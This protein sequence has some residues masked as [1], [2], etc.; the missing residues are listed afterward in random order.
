MIDFAKELNE[1]QFEVVTNGEG[2]CLVLAGA[3]S[4]KTRAITYRVAYLLEKGVNPNNILLVTF[5]NK[6]AKEMINRVQLLTNGEIKLPWS[7]TFHH[8]A[9]RILRQYA[10]LLNYKNNFSVLDSQ[11]SLDLFKLCLK[12]EG[13]DKK[14]KR[15]PS[16]KIIQSIVSYARNAGDSLEEVLDLKYPSWLPIADIIGRIAQEYEFRK[17]DANV[18]DF[19]DL[20]TNLYLLLL[21]SDSVREKFSSQFKYVLVDEY[22]D[23]NKI[24][25]SIIKQFASHHK[26]ILVVGDDAQSIYSFRAADIS[27]ILNFEKEYPNAKIY[28]LETNYRSTPDILH[29]A[30][31]VISNN[32][33]QYEKKLKSMLENYA[34][35]ELQAFA[36][37]Q[38]EANFIANRITEL[39]EDGVSF[40]KMSVLFR[41]AY[42]S[43]ALEV[44][45]TKRGIPYEY[46]GGIRF[47]ERAHIKDALA[48]LRIWSN[49]DD[50]VAW[51]R[52][53]N[54][55]VGIGPAMVQTIASRIK[56]LDDLTN[57]SGSLP[58]RAQVGWNDF[59]QIW[60]AMEKEIHKTPSAL[61]QA[62]IGSKYREYLENEYPDAR[63]RMQDLEQLAVF[64]A[65]QEDLDKFLAEAT[66]QEGYNSAQAQGD[67]TQ[68]GSAEKLVLST[69]HQ[70][71]GLEWE[72]VFIINLSTGQFPSEKSMRSYKDIEEERRLFYV[73]ITRAKKYLYL[74]YPLSGNFGGY[75]QGPSM[76]LEEIN[77]E[78]LESAV[79]KNST[80][81][82]SDDDISYV[83]EDEPFSSGPRPSF[84]RSVDDL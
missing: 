63:E 66:L 8:I 42:H 62:L 13:L 24:Q 10:P 15:F 16:A 28:R 22:Q 21:K 50:A 53:L 17:R 44:E 81:F 46:R 47:F 74:T 26:N 65:R 43:Q 48:Y 69:I 35:P 56:N 71:K 12:K 39:S 41:A 82:K 59:M 38:E 68:N 70:A 84:L 64:S 57:L 11:D 14:E 7:G 58:A 34:K 76:F 27:N 73:A 33:N 32:R 30:N 9:Y 31:D 80:I 49:R 1:E 4:G 79:F 67:H 23:T 54:M 52:V 40:D 5:T 45:L 60:E 75:M 37:N 2:P 6:A 25:A 3:G 18:M 61:L 72:G 51:S 20:L 55:Q 36:D 29:V 19:D 77:N 83:N 78:L